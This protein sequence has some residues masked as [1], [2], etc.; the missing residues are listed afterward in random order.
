MLGRPLP[1]FNMPIVTGVLFTTYFVRMMSTARAEAG[2][3]GVTVTGVAFHN[4]NISMASMAPL[5]HCVGY[6]WSAS[7]MAYKLYYNIFPQ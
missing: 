1:H 3:A 2:V 7:N 5:L 6:L 4:P